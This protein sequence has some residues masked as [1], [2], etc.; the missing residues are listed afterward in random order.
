MLYHTLSLLLSSRASC[1]RVA[2][3]GAV[4]KNKKYKKVGSF[5]VLLLVETY[6]YCS[7]NPINYTTLCSN[8][9]DSC[10]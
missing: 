7:E 1:V 4:A 3:A 2:A 5:F 9:K 10:R 8:S 6:N